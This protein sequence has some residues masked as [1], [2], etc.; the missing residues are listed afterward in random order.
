MIVRLWRRIRFVTPILKIGSP[1]TLPFLTFDF[2]V[3]QSSI[4]IYLCDSGGKVS[5]RP[6]GLWAKDWYWTWENTWLAQYL[7]GWVF[8]CPHSLIPFTF[9]LLPCV[10]GNSNLVSLLWQIR[11]TDVTRTWVRPFIFALV[12]HEP[13]PQISSVGYSTLGHQRLKR[14]VLLQECCKVISLLI[15]LSFRMALLV[16]RNLAF[17]HWVK[18][19]EFVK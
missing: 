16:C 11:T 5:M 15:L 19:E 12:H 8:W 1:D 4:Q 14:N 6:L 13:R 18:V 17:S 7:D 10:W 9:L 3:L 2:L